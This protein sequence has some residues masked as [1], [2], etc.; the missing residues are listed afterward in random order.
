M[1]GLRPNEQITLPFRSLLPAMADLCPSHLA[2]YLPSTT[3]FLGWN[4][5]N[6]CAPLSTDA[7]SSNVVMD[8]GNNPMGHKRRHCWAGTLTLAMPTLRRTFH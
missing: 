5:R 3:C 1:V 7:G 6:H 8:T 2:Q 4:R